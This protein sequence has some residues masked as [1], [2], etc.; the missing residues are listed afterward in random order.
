VTGLA[1]VD[2]ARDDWPATHP[3]LAVGQ[4]RARRRKLGQR[5]KGLQQ[6][7]GMRPVESRSPGAGL[8]SGLKPGMWVPTLAVAES[9]WP[10]RVY[11]ADRVLV[12][13]PA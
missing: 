8:D 3:V 4:A 11:P 2:S 13:V 12:I 7:A 6:A 10:D 5:L 1:A 9:C